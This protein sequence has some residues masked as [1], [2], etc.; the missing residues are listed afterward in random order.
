MK[1]T[2]K[3]SILTHKLSI[4]SCMVDLYSRAGLVEKA[5]IVPNN[6]PFPTCTTMAL[7]KSICARLVV[8][9][10]T[11][12]IWQERSNRIFKK[13]SRKVEQ[14]T[15][16]IIATIRLKVISLRF[17]KSMKVAKVLD[18]WKISNETSSDG[19]G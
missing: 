1:K 7:S 13:K 14:V 6:M 11:Y 16:V 12:F 3:T 5:L 17:K 9:A 4:Y 8:A 19:S 15:D 2:I 10:S 18:V